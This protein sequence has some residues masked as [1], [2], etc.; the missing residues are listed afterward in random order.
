MNN[1]EI[2]MRTTMDVMETCWEADSPYS[3]VVRECERL[4]LRVPSEVEYDEYC[5]FAFEAI[6]DWYDAVGGSDEDGAFDAGGHFHADRMDMDF[7][8]R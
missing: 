5:E 2:N 3:D 8:D 6:Q 1:M 7:E 4:D